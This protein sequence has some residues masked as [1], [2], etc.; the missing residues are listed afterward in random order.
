MMEAWKGAKPFRSPLPSIYMNKML[1]K[2]NGQYWM[3]AYKLAGI[4]SAWAIVIYAF[5]R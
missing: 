3:P 5:A 2:K 1:R 4:A